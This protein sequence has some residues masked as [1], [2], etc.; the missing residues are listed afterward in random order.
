MPDDPKI[1]GLRRGI[2]DEQ[3]P[4]GAWETYYQA[5]AGDISVTVEAYA[6]LRACGM[7]AD[8]P[9]C[10]GPASGYSPKA[11]FGKVRVFTRYWLALIGEWPWEKTPNIPP[12][13]IFFPRWFAF[14]YL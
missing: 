4:D 13:I 3:R 6:A 2:L 1:E 7:P 14:Q 8:A 11:D 12:E 10:S 5:P 9:P